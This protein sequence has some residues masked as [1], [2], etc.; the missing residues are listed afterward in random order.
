MVDPSVTMGPLLATPI[1]TVNP[2]QRPMPSTPS[3]LVSSVTGSRS[4][5]AASRITTKPLAMMPIPRP[6]PLVS[7]MT[8]PMIR[9]IISAVGTTCR[10]VSTALMLATIGAAIA[11]SHS[12]H[13]VPS[14]NLM[15]QMPIEQMN[16]RN[17]V[18]APRAA[19]TCE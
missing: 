18:Q 7:A 13:V 10:W 12:S 3:G 14:A 8:P 9:Q 15:T 16:S 11:A 6:T 19:A 17:P 1:A 5:H 4:S 2:S